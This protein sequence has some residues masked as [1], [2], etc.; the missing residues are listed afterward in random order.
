MRR[1]LGNLEPLFPQDMAHRERAK[2]G[3]APGEPGTGAHGWEE[4]AEALTTPCAV[5]DRHRVTK[6][7]DR[8][9]IVALSPVCLAPALLRPRLQNDVSTAHG[10]REGTLT[11]GDGLVIG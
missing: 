11:G 1:R 2:L 10:E 3:M 5:E 8:P 7:V 4:E 9:P 6:A